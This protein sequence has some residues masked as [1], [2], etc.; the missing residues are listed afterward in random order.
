[1]EYEIDIIIEWLSTLDWNNILVAI[2][3]LILRLIPSRNTKIKKG[4]KELK[5]IVEKNIDKKE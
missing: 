3:A 5:T 1:M 2:F 4:I